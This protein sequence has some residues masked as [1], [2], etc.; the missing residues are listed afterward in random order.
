LGVPNGI[1]DG[2]F[3]RECTLTREARCYDG[4]AFQSRV[5][6]IREPCTIL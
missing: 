3:P 2:A 6:I 1:G 5:E 4:L